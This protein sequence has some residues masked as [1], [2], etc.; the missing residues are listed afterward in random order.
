[1]S[2]NRSASNPNGETV[3]FKNAAAWVVHDKARARRAGVKAAAAVAAFVLL[4]A[5]VIG[6]TNNQTGAVRQASPTVALEPAEREETPATSD[7]LPAAAS[8][9][10]VVTGFMNAWLAAPKF[11]KSKRGHAQWVATMKPYTD[12][13]LI[14]LLNMSPS[15][16]GQVPTGKGGEPLQ[17]WGL[18]P[19]GE[20][21][22]VA[23]M[24][25]TLTNRTDV[26]V[27]VAGLP[28]GW[29]VTQIIPNYKRAR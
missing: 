7:P 3:V 16:L 17:V 13:S 19:G 15:T 27:Y 12:R 23:S 10:Q 24:V 14:G 9:Q 20:I 21:G 18:T 6:V 2:R 8:I 5:V 1:M 22:S 4:M 26:K 11:E 29:R 25:A 28:E